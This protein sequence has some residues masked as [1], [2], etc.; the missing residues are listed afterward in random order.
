MDKVIVFLH[1]LIWEMGF[2]SE[3]IISTVYI[4]IIVINQSKASLIEQNG[5]LCNW[6]K[7]CEWLEN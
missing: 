5:V 7:V 6:M 1:V 4:H 2:K 3:K